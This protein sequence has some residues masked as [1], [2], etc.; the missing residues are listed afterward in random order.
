MITCDFSYL[1]ADNDSTIHKKQA[2]SMEEEEIYIPFILSITVIYMHICFMGSEKVPSDN[3]GLTTW[4]GA[5]T[6]FQGLVVRKGAWVR[7]C[8]LKCSVWRL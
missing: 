5:S 4:R 2:V 6:K 3:T 1:S 7:L 8:L